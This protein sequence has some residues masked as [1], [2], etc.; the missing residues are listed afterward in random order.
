MC[1]AA[2]PLAALGAARHSAVLAVYRGPIAHLANLP[3]RSGVAA[4]YGSVVGIRV[5]GVVTHGV[6]GSLAAP[7]AGDDNDHREER[8]SSGPH[9]AMILRKG[10]A[11]R[12]PREYGGIQDAHVPR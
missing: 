1:C 3:W 7:S 10:R 9:Q 4:R 2:V 8:R 11:K 5:R 6:S 12:T